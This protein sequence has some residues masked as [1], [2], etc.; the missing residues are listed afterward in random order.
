VRTFSDSL[1]NCESEYIQVSYWQYGV[2]ASWLDNLESDEEE[3]VDSTT[4]FDSFQ[5]RDVF[6]A[7]TRL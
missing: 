3:A 5:A 7:A 4:G 6:Q 2:V 1:V